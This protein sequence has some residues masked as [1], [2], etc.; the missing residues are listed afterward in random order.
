MKKQV[1]IAGAGAG[2]EE[3]RTAALV[4]AVEEAGLIIGP[5]RIVR[6]FAVKGKT[7]RSEYRPE[8]VRQI[9]DE[10]QEENI[11]V[12][13][14]G[15]PGFY[16]AAYGMR[17]KLSDY[18]PRVLPGISSI[19]YFSAR[20]GIPYSNALLVS[21]HGRELNL[22]SLVRRNRQ[23]FVLT[24][25]NL[26]ELLE[27]LSAYGYGDLEIYTGEDLS[28]DRERIR[29]G[30]AA[31]L[32]RQAGKEPFSVLSLMAVNNPKAEE[33]VPA[34]LPDDD[35]LRGKVP[36][37]KREV[38]AVILSSLRLL[39]DSVVVDIGSGTGS[40]AVEAALS[41]YKGTVYAVER[42]QEALEL[43]R[44]NA[45]RFHVDN[46]RVVEGEAPEALEKLPVADAYF[47]GG[48]GGRLE[49]ILQCIRKKLQQKRENDQPEEK[50]KPESGCRVVISAI[51][52][53]TLTKVVQIL[54]EM[55]VRDSSW[56]QLQV[57]RSHRT[58]GYDLMKAE[59][60]VF[61]L[62]ADLSAR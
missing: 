23:T 11:L 8:V 20:I 5:D 26:V 13:V 21:A 14:T 17:E 49:E 19:A 12:L 24:G 33:A 6:S 16:S 52:L 36:M 1:I 57:S 59:N 42:K 38:R 37:T 51:T 54:E 53:Q 29:H 28:S 60:P 45:I 39:A 58:G 30:S 27:R 34:G 48:S 61:L 35:F 44:A 10:A 32:L 40:V 25:G 31:E 2:S 41:A 50:K 55:H 7:V 9:V 43:I 22:V 4:S 56:T 47:I 18:A 15:D 62:T 3:S 46:L